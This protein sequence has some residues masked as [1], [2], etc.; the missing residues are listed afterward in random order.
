[1]RS[2]LSSAWGD[3][4]GLDAG[5]HMHTAR[6]AWSAAMGMALGAGTALTKTTVAVVCTLG[7]ELR[8][9]S[10]GAPVITSTTHTQC[11]LKLSSS[12]SKNMI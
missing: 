3:A 8:W 2:C 9:P 1:M 12:N 6:S 7:K 10:Q 4:C 11:Q 5:G